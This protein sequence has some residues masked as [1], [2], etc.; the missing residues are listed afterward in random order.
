MCTMHTSYLSNYTFVTVVHT[1]IHLQPHEQMKITLK[2][3]SNPTQIGLEREKHL[4]LSQTYGMYYSSYFK[5][6]M[7][8]KH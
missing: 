6:F 4:I 8:Q 7:T 1:F 2:R 3:K 5:Q